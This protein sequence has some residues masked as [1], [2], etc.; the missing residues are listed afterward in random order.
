MKALA[1]ITRGFVYNTLERDVY[2]TNLNLTGEFKTGIFDHKLLVGAD[3][4]D[5]SDNWLGYLGADPR[6]STLN[7]FNPQYPNIT[8]LLRSLAYES[9]N[10]T[11]WTTNEEDHGIYLQDQISL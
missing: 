5:Y 8:E 4:F 3:W 1:D 6:I 7:I 2:G 10:N 11:V 9:R